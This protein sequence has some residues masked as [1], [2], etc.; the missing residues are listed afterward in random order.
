MRVLCLLRVEQTSLARHVK[1]HVHLSFKDSYIAVEFTCLQILTFWLGSTQTAKPRTGSWIDQS[2]CRML[3]VFVLVYLH[4]S[5]IYAYSSIPSQ[6]RY[7]AMAT[8][9]SGSKSKFSLQGRV[10]IP[11]KCHLR[12]INNENYQAAIPKQE[13]ESESF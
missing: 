8:G 6:G 9:S 11:G 13:S 5:S 7:A 10:R 1:E 3:G 12:T 4:L 2:A